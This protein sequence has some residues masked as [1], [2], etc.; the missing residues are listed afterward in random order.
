MGRVLLVQSIT[1]VSPLSLLA[2]HTHTHTHI[3]I[4][5]YMTAIYLESTILPTYNAWS[6]AD[7]L[8]VVL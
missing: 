5:I 6:D 2:I 7:F 8:A 1:Y 4:Y 3:Y